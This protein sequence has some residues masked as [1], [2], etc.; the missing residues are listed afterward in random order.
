MATYIQGLTDY[1]PQIQPFK[2]D[3]NFYST[4]LQTR[5][6][7]HDAARAKLGSLYGSLLYSPLTHPDNIARR[8]EFFKTIEQD[9]KKVSGLDLS[10]Q[11]N[12]DA[13]ASIFEPLINDKS[14]AHDMS[15]TK[16]ESDQMQAGEG[17]RFSNDPDKNGGYYSPEAAAAIQY[18][19]NEYAASD[20]NQRLSMQPKRFTPYYN[21][22]KMALD[23]AKNLGWVATA[24]KKGGGYIFKYS[25]GMDIEPE[26]QQAFEANFANDPRFQEMYDTKAYVLRHNYIESK[27]NEMSQD[28][29]EKSWFNLVMSQTAPVLQKEID[30][31]DNMKGDL[32]LKKAVIE[33]TVAKNGAI[34]DD[35][36][37]MEYLAAQ[38]N[39]D[40][41]D[42]LNASNEK[43]KNSMKSIGSGS[44]DVNHMRNQIDYLVSR[45]MLKQDLKSA[46][47]IFA[48]ANSAITDMSADPYA[49]SLY[50]HEL[51]IR[52]SYVDAG[53]DIIKSIELANIDLK[54]QQ[55]LAFSTAGFPGDNVF[56]EVKNSPG[57]VTGTGT[58]IYEKTIEAIESLSGKSGAD[59]LTA[60]SKSYVETT[61]NYLLSE[62]NQSDKGDTGKAYARKLLKSMYGSAY[63]AET[64]KFV[65]NDIEYDSWSDLNM[66]ESDLNTLYKNALIINSKNKSIYKDLY[67]NVERMHQ[68]YDMFDK[69]R[70]AYA[71]QMYTNVYG[72]LREAGNT[73]PEYTKDP[74]GFMKMFVDLGNNKM[75]ILTERQYV[76]SIMQ[77]PNTKWTGSKLN[78]TQK[79]EYLQKQYRSYQSA[80]ASVYNKGSEAFRGFKAPFALNVGLGADGGIASNRVMLKTNKFIPTLAGNYYLA[81]VQ[82]DIADGNV[83]K[84][85][86]GDN[87]TKDDFEKTDTDGNAQA[88]FSAYISDLASG[89]FTTDSSKEEAPFADVLYGKVAAN[90][91]D[92]NSV[93]LANINPA[94]LKKYQ[95]E[96][97]KK[98]FGQDISYWMT[99]GVSAYLNG[100]AAE[101][102]FAKALSVKP[103]D[104]L[105]D[106]GPVTVKRENAGLLKIT[107][108][109]QAASG[110]IGSYVVEGNIPGY[111]GNGNLGVVKWYQEEN[112]AS[113]NDI[114][115]MVNNLMD[116]I[117]KQNT[118]YIQSGGKTRYYDINQLLSTLKTPLQ[119][120]QTPNA[121]MG[122]INSQEALKS[123]Q[124]QFQNFMG[125]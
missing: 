40:I 95:D 90:R 9:I 66:G 69:Q 20:L 45:G 4:V 116:A 89:R 13:A 124:E 39:I 41:V 92:L 52:K 74:N 80:F 24:V 17:L 23:Y 86:P 2:P 79:K 123:F 43:I 36:L 44:D 28:E 122:R 87:H 85:L 84:Y 19:L 61:T 65:K 125:R 75:G 102:E 14:I 30:G 8:D 111:D 48:K 6:N 38:N 58:P 97:T 99:K 57:S 12:V 119:G 93:T 46:A 15:F 53:I 91:T 94:W 71:S 7:R 82:K 101:N 16:Y 72:V 88:L 104:V 110:G 1:I 76:E 26:I 51:S 42:K 114:V 96:K 105:L 54:K 25:N 27:K 33:N 77:D 113:G 117:S 32:T 22:Q 81:T 55:G 112:R 107:K 109:G 115:V 121:N 60:I 62:A 56:K 108:K 118:A 47:D 120:A 78:E 70:N 49:K 73:I 106:Q 35:P 63:N 37:A 50:D 10:L 59:G 5:Q 31:L 21:T 67:S 34:A 11:E 68:T 18:R 83:L 3:L 64:N 103:Y 98:V 100:D 29:A